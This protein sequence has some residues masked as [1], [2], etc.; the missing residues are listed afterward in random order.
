MQ[1]F[2]QCGVDSHLARHMSLVAKGINVW[3]HALRMQ[4]G[5]IRDRVIHV[6]VPCAGLT[7]HQLQTS[8]L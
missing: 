2:G 5:L 1:F 7:L 4:D 8:T 3:A 6:S